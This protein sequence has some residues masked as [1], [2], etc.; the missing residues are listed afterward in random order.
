[1]QAKFN[2]KLVKIHIYSFIKKQVILKKRYRSSD[3]ENQ[4]ATENSIVIAPWAPLEEEVISELNDSFKHHV[5]ITEIKDE[6][7]E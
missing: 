2:L 5:S 1:M 6:I 3:I 4:R 7:N